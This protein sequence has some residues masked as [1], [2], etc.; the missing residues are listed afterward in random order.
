MQVLAL[1]CLVAVPQIGG[2]F[3]VARPR[4]VRA[5]RYSLHTQTHLPSPIL[6]LQRDTVEVLTGKLLAELPGQVVEYFHSMKHIPPPPRGAGGP[7]PAVSMG[8][9]AAVSL[10]NPAPPP[11]QPASHFP[12]I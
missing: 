9:Q 5:L 12:R 7:P 10:G 6:I 1:F 11:T 2:P 4:F 8:R 3:R